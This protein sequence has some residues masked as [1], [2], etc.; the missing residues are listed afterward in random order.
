VPAMKRALVLACAA[1]ALLA[2]R[3]AADVKVPSVFASHMVLQRD[4]PIVVWG[5]ADKGESVTVSFAGK[6]ATAKADDDGKWKVELPKLEPNAKGQSMTIKGNNTLE[7]EDV[8]VGDVWLGSGQSNME[9]SLAASADPTKTIANAKH[10]NIRLLHVKKV[11]KNT[12][13][14]D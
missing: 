5:W 2:G 6:E 8:L 4:K 3:A 7:L 1:A 14:N 9:W 13:Q 11:Q 12:P 10:P